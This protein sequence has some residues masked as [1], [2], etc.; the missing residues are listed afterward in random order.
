MLQEADPEL[1]GHGRRKKSRSWSRRS[2]GSRTNLKSC[3]CRKTPTTRK[4]SCWKFARAPGGD[5]ATLF[6]AEIFRMYTRFAE[7]RRWS[8]EV[9]SASESAVGGLKEVIALISGDKVY[10]P[11]EVRK[12]RAS[13]AARSG[14]RTAGPRTH[15]GRHRRGA[16]RSGRSRNQHRSEGHPHRYVLLFRPRRPVREHDVFGRAHHA[17][18]DGPGGLLPGRKIADQEP[19]EGRCACCAR[20]STKWSWR[21]SRQRSARSGAAWWARGDRSEKIRTYNFPQNRVTDH[22]I[23]LTLH[24][25][26][27][28]MEG[29]LD[30]HRRCADHVL[31]DREAQRADRP[32]PTGA[33]A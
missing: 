6:A 22:R 3:C 11:A 30:P 2:R 14:N 4:T 12:R 24:Q 13:R 28:V 33:A 32:Q 21:S 27:Q 29:K 8:V 1:R 25:L 7:T 20:G 31:P 23:G 9:T 18:A 26:D 16:P 19:R 17:P 10:Q 5:E 15:L